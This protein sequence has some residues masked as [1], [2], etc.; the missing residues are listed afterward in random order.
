M[1]PQYLPRATLQFPSTFSLVP[2]VMARVTIV[3]RTF[4][5]DDLLPRFGQR[6]RRYARRVNPFSSL[7]VL[8]PPLENGQPWADFRPFRSPRQRNG[9]AECDSGGFFV[10]QLAA[11]PRRS[12]A[13]AHCS[14]YFKTDTFL[15]G[16]E[17]NNIVHEG[18]II[19]IVRRACAVEHFKLRR[20][21]C[22]DP[23]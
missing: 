18:L 9:L 7:V 1:S 20:H 4:L 5:L 16:K 2:K 19:I 11:N 8:L 22:S 17:L 6:R 21:C 23:M 15:Q 10:V 12:D 14:G 3:F 13:L